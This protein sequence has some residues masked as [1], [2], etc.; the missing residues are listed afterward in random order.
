MLEAL[1]IRNARVSRSRGAI[2][3]S[4]VALANAIQRDKA[5]SLLSVDTKI[6]PKNGRWRCDGGSLQSGMRQK[7]DETIRK[8]M[9][10]AE[11]VTSD[12][13]LGCA[14]V[15]IVNVR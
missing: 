7:Q 9:H 10:K 3:L 8:H 1:H 2:E 12:S 6:A 14:D 15:A 5:V 4:Y 11:V 13:V